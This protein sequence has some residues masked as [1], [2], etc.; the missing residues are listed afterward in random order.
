MTGETDLD[1]GAA[2]L[3]E[4]YP[5]IRLL[6]VTA[7]PEGSCSY[8]ENRRVFVPACKLGGVIETTGAG[9]T[10]CA[11]VLHFVLAHGLEGLTAEDLTAML[12]FANTAA[13]LVT[14]RKGAIRSMPEREQVEALL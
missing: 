8:Y 14:T 9:D 12:R 1:Q 4:K 7:G 13:Y 11:C 5:N 6:N 2:I 3:R 10:F